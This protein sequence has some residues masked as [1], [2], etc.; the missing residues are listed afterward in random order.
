MLTKTRCCVAVVLFCVLTALAA[1]QG[2]PGGKTP[3]LAD[4]NPLSE[5]E[6]QTGVI[7]LFDGIS[8]FGWKNDAKVED[9][10]LSFTGNLEKT[11]R[12]FLSEKKLEGLTW[13]LGVATYHG[14][15]SGISLIDAKPLATTPL[16]D[17]KT[18]TGWTLYGKAEAEVKDGAIRLTNGSGS[19][20]SDGKYGDFVLQL[21]YF[22][23]VRPEGK[24][25][26][27]G[28]FFRCIP[29]EIMNGYE[30]QIL[31]NPGEDDYKNYIGTDTGGIFR[32]QVGRNIGP[33]DGE[34]N[35]LTI[36][37]KEARIATWVNG[38]QAA[39][40]TDERAPHNNPRNG[41]R[42]EAGTIQF[43]AHDPE[44]EVLFRNI[45]IQEL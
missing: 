42:T 24:G 40:W 12:W 41:R 45:R 18:L 1:A 10:I 9:G 2:T 38:I 23:P 13:Q 3:H 31:N 16:F 11:P 4:F 22:T 27:S 5:E 7:R 44:T 14:K 28:V 21:E 26:N 30:C 33:K 43:Q 37:A 15:I 6:L 29:G 39:D 20:E 34:W 25:V 35:Y 19:L 17:G 36:A 8:T 32:R